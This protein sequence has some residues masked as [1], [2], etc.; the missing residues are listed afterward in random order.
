MKTS[1]LCRMPETRQVLSGCGQVTSTFFL[2]EDFRSP[3]NGCQSHAMRT[4]SRTITPGFI[5]EGIGDGNCTD[6]AIGPGSASQVR[7]A[8]CLQRHRDLQCPASK[9]GL[10]GQSDQSLLPGNVPHGRLRIHGY[11]PFGGASAR[12]RRIFKSRPASRGFQRDPSPADRCLP[13]PR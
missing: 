10:H 11:L 5:T 6:F 13:R 7:H 8:H 3:T 4:C 12:R 9:H 1:Q 2:A